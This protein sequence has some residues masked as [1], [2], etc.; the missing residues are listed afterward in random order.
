M[1]KIKYL[2]G[3]IL[4]MNY[5]RLFETVKLCH[6]R[7]G[8]NSIWLFFDI[9]YCGF[10]YGAGHSDYRLCEFYNLTPPQR[11]TYV[12]R[13]INNQLVRKLNDPEACAQLE[14]KTCFNRLFA[15]QIGRDWLDLSS[16]SFEEFEAFMKNRE[17]IIA[18]PVAATCG[19]GVRKVSS[20]DYPGL[21]EM[22]EDLI[23][24]GSTLVEEYIRQHEDLSGLYP[25]SVNTLRIVTV[26]TEGT[27]HV[28][29][30][31]IRMGNGGRVVDNINAGGMTAP[32]RLA[33]GVIQ[34]AAF[35]KNSVYYE[36][37]PETGEKIA[38]FVIPF[39][40]E[41]MELCKS[42]ALMVPKVGYIGW[43]VAVTPDGPILIEANH[44]PGHDFLQMPPHVPD[45]IG[46]LPR[47]REFVEI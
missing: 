33:D 22:Y 26:L 1:A 30:S 37:H 43:D 14:D 16:A 19:V 24:T 32:I 28:V 17:S 36:T 34:Y 42:A 31:Y 13:G 6:K 2:L 15:A 9:I 20:G 21:R 3:R 38:G 23:K 4:K 40:Q 41:A 47:F 18:K 10:R 8:K 29:Y 5:G 44:F 25:H 39:W 12:T 45:K 35:D 11:A 7:S 27:P 46:M